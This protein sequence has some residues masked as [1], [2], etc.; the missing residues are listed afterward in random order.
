MQTKQLETMVFCHKCRK[1]GL[2]IMHF[3]KETQTN[4]GLGKGKALEIFNSN[5]M[6]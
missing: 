1:A 3:L 5:I 4:I 2:K 6:I